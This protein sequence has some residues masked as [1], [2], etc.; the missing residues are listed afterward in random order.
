MDLEL[1]E[2]VDSTEP[3]PAPTQ[4]TK[5]TKR[6]SAK[7]T[8]AQKAGLKKHMDK[9]KKDGMSASEMK[10]HRMKLMARMRKDP[11]M[12]AKKAHNAVMKG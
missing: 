11:K 10:S 6:Q 7:M 1:V 8:D 12:T 4:S 2:N 3:A 9:M 5:S